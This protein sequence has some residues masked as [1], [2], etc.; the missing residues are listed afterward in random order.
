MRADFF[1]SYDKVIT[2]VFLFCDISH[3]P[4]NSPSKVPKSVD[5]GT[6]TQLCSIHHYLIP[7]RVITPKRNRP[8]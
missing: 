1:I 2:G 8:H 7:E 5:L 3:L 4:Y 6:V